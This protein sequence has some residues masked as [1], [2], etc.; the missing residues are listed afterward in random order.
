MINKQPIPYYLVDGMSVD[1]ESGTLTVKPGVEFA[2]EHGHD[3]WFGGSIQIKIE[4]TL[5]APVT[6]RGFMDEASYWNGIQLSTSRPSSISHLVIANAGKDESYSLDF[7]DNIKVDVNHIVFK[8]NENYC[9]HIAHDAKVTNVGALSFD[10]CAKG[11]IYDDRLEG[12]D[13][14][15]VLIDL[16]VVTQ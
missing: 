8:S 4:G 16:P 2:I 11:N 13:D 1:G 5:E 7:H 10:N 3:V 15:K 6:M 12:D 14:S 9:L